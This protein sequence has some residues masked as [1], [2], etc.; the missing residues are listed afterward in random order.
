MNLIS[1]RQHLAM[2]TASY[3]LTSLILSPTLFVVVLTILFGWYIH[4]ARKYNHWSSMGVPGPKP[5]FLSGNLYEFFA[6]ESNKLYAKW[7]KEYGKLVGI[8]EGSKPI[9]LTTDP[10]LIKEVFIKN[11]HI[12]IDRR[13][14]AGDRYN[15]LNLANKKGDDWKADRRI[16]SPT[17]TSGKMKAM[18]ALMLECYKKLEDE[19]ARVERRGDEADAKILFSK[20]TSTVIARC[21]FATVIDPYTE[22]NDPLLKSLHGM[23]DVAKMRL[24]LTRLLPDWFKNMVE[25]QGNPEASSYVQRVCKEIVRKR[26]ESAKNGH[27]EYNDFIQLLINAGHELTGTAPSEPDH[28]SHHGMEDDPDAVKAINSTINNNSSGK[29][30]LTEDEIIANVIIFF[31]AGFET[32]ST[33]LSFASFVLTNKPDV[34][35]KLYRELKATFDEKNGQFDYETLSSHPYLDSFICETLRLYSPANRIERVANQEYKLSNGISVKKG[36][37]IGVPLD[38]L[39]RDPEYFDEPE[40]FDLERFLPQN[41]GKIIPY[42]YLPFGTGP[43]NCI[44]MRFALLEAKMALANS[45][46]KYKFVSTGKT[47]RQ[48]KYKPL[49]P[50]LTPE[51]PIMIKLEKR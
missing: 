23:F 9:L 5:K 35:E 51:G 6:L 45:M 18:F 13:G 16:M 38:T 25:F 30:T 2:D 42:T 19:L 17:F 14:G 46:M 44:G 43:R 28:E 21:A 27:G 26:K 48:L 36:H 3:S 37:T 4:Y 34:Q 15:R 10:D 20:L 1:R 22:E 40:K 31:L 47:T 39:Q 50:I 12:F 41:R 7:T 8:Y 32:T 29:K 49:N 24:I 11:G 33:L